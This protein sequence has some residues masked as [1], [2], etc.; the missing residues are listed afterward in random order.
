MLAITAA[1]LGFPAYVLLTTAAQLASFRFQTDRFEELSCASS[2]ASATPPMA[3][4][5]AWCDGHLQTQV[6]PSGHS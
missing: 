1:Q 6:V 5:T 2:S 4:P 3:A